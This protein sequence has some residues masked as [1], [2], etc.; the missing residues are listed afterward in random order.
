MDV[1]GSG[2]KLMVFGQE[3]EI[4]EEAATEQNEANDEKE[5]GVASHEKEKDATDWGAGQGGV[6][7]VGRGDR[8]G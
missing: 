8:T 1:G 6:G 3:E 5:F 7:R 2:E 4:G